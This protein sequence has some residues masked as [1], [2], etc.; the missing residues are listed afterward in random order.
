MLGDLN[1]LNPQDV[2]IGGD[3]IIGEDCE[4]GFC[5]TFAAC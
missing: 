4:Y 5:D 3:R 1:S 2:A